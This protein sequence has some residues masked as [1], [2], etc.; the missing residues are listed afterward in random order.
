MKRPIR[1]AQEFAQYVAQITGWESW[2]SFHTNFGRRQEVDA[3]GH[4]C[5]ITLPLLRGRANARR[6]HSSWRTVY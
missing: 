4:S 5:T 6:V 1:R 3:Y 2:W